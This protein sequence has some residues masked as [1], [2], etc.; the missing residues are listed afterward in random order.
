MPS[1]VAFDPEEPS[2]G[3]S[4]RADSVAPPHSPVT[5][6]QLPSNDAAFLE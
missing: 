4:I 1:K 6:K 3:C 2:L 5:I